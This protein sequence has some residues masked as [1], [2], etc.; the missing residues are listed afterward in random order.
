MLGTDIS[1]TL[2]AILYVSF[3]LTKKKMLYIHDFHIITSDRCYR[4]IF[5]AEKC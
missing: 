5:V 2:S 1:I 4:V 3:Y